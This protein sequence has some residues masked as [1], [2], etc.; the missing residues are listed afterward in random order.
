MSRKICSGGL[1]SYEVKPYKKP[2]LK[3]IAYIFSFFYLILVCLPLFL[4][5]YLAVEIIFSIRDLKKF[6][7][8]TIKNEKTKPKP[9]TT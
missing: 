2:K 8:K 4:T 1:V 5:I 7:K 6:I 3:L 9:I